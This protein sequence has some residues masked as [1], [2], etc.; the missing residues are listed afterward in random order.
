MTG[1]KIGPGS[2]KCVTAWSA[3][4]PL[5]DLL[6]ETLRTHVAA[7]DIRHLCGQVFLVYT[8]AAASAVRDWL[9]PRLE[10][11]ESA[12]V[13]AFEE[14]SGYGPGPDRRWLL[15]RGH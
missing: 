14:W 9:V 4:R 8:D 11:E 1:D 15:R 3:R 12:F 2:L 6:E 7:Q 13:V 5:R 10:D